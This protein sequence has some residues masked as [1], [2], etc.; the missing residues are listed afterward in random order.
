MFGVVSALCVVRQPRERDR[1]VRV[2][3]A[4]AHVR[5]ILTRSACDATTVEM[6]M[7]AIATEKPSDSACGSSP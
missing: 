3:G 2:P 7:S 1:A 4:A 6:T 5:A